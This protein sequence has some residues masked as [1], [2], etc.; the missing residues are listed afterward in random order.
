MEHVE[1]QHI[2]RG[3][4]SVRDG[5]V[6]MSED[7]SGAYTLC[8]GHEV[9]LPGPSNSIRTNC[10]P[11]RAAVPPSLSASIRSSGRNARCMKRSHP[12]TR[13]CTVSA[14]STIGL[15]CKNA[16]PSV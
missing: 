12:T 3:L 11:C 6:A 5:L 2:Q 16:L 10:L 9:T 1:V 8:L 15:V 4:L 14:V 13:C 7:Q